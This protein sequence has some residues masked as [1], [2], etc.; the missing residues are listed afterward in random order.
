M[1]D[2]TGSYETPI[3]VSAAF[4]LV[5]AVCVMLPKNPVQVAHRKVP[6]TDLNWN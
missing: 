4:C 6:R 5:A 2:L 3:L 1:F